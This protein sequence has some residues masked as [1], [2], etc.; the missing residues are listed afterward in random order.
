MSSLERSLLRS[1][2]G[3]KRLIM[4]RASAGVAAF[5]VGMIFVGRRAFTHAQSSVKEECSE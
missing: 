1:I 3:A 4:A 2:S 5:T